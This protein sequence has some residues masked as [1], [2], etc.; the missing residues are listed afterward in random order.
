MGDREPETAI[1]KQPHPHLG[2]ERS[3]NWTG[4]IAIR[5]SG[6]RPVRLT[7]TIDLW[8]IERTSVS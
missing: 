8:D 6:F 1:L 4:G 2:P 5:R 3:R 7:L